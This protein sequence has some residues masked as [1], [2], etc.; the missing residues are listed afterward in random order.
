LNFATDFKIHAYSLAHQNSQ[1][2]KSNTFHLNALAFAGHKLD[3]RRLKKFYFARRDARRKMIYGLRFVMLM[4]EG[5]HG[6]S[7]YQNKNRNG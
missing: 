3:L 2:N 5:G 1:S 4:D 6:D 7:V